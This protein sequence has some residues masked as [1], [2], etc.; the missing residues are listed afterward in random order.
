MEPF[1]PVF[2]NLSSPLTLT[3]FL[4]TTI[5]YGIISPY[6]SSRYLTFYRS[7]PSG[8]KD[9]WNSLPVSTV[10]SIITT[11]LCTYAILFGHDGSVETQA[12]MKTRVGTVSLQMSLGFFIGDLVL[13]L[14]SSYLRNDRLMFVH[15]FTSLTSV[16]FGLLFS[17]RWM[18]LILLRLTSE[19]STPFVNLRW[20]LYETNTQK[21]SK[22]YLFCAY[23][24]TATFF[25]SRIFIIPVNWYFLVK[26]MLYEH[27]LPIPE[28]KVSWP[29]QMWCV[30]AFVSLDSLNLFWG[31]KMARG[32]AKIVLGKH[33]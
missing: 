31:Y 18:I 30:F 23:G 15:H 27:S 11:S 17:G 6:L 2:I 3:S 26:L 22:I 20:L 8:K 9:Y 29:L 19:L 33:L 24:M 25:I 10:H 14:S 1:T 12:L 28:Y 32:F 7:L 4:F 21:N 16:A 13:I 5:V